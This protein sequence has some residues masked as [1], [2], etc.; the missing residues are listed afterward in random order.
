MAEAVVHL[1][2]DADRKL[3]TSAVVG[4]RTRIFP[5]P[6]DRLS[7][8]GSGLDMKFILEQKSGHIFYFYFCHCE[9]IRA[10]QSLD[11]IASATASQ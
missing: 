7:V 3:E 2:K 11:G 4:G 5:S 1:A 9:I 6:F 10:K 8:F